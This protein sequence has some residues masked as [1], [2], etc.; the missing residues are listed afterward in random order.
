M[1]PLISNKAEPTLALKTQRRPH[2]KSET[3]VSVAPQKGL[4]SSK[5]FFK[6]KK[7]RLKSLSSGELTAQTE[8]KR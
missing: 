5:I 8:N 2:Q 6:K 3:G 7:S 4:M 1:P